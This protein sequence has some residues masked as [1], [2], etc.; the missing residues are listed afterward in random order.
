M[1]WRARRPPHTGKSLPPLSNRIDV[2]AW[3]GGAWSPPGFPVHKG[4]L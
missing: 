3:F 2:V 4:C 1:T